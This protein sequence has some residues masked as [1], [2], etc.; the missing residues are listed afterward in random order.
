[1]LAVGFC[2][3]MEIAMKYA[4]VV[5]SRKGLKTPAFHTSCHGGRSLVQALFIFEIIL[6]MFL[7]SSPDLLGMASDHW[8]IVRIP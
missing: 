8:G 5:C 2:G 4:I 3:Q 1:M 6:L 7:D